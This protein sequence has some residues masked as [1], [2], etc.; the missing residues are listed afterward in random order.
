MKNI[1][2]GRK[3]IVMAVLIG[4]L[5]LIIMASLSF[6]YARI[7]LET[8]VDKQTTIFSNLAIQKLNDHFESIKANAELASTTENVRNMLVASE[9]PH[10]TEADLKSAQEAMTTFVES[11][12]DTLGYTEVFITDAKG[13]VVVANTMAESLMDA[14]LSSRDYLKS[15]LTGTPQWSELF[16]SD[17]VK[18]NVMLYSQPIYQLDTGGKI[19]GTIN[20]VFD[21][22]ALN[23]IV[24]YAVDEIGVTGNAYII[25]AEGML[26]T[27]MTIGEY[28][29]NAAMNATI[30][31][32]AVQLLKQEI[33][34]GNIAYRHSGHYNDIGE[35]QVLGTLSVVQFGRLHGGLIIE[36]N[37]DEVFAGT[38]RLMMTQG[39]LAVVAIIFALVISILISRS[40]T[41]PINELVIHADEIANYNIANDIPEAYTKRKDEIGD[42]ASALNQV[43][44]NLKTLLSE[45]LKTAEMVAA[46]SEQLTATSQQSSSAATEVAETIEEIARGASDQA[47]QTMQGTEQ[48]IVLGEHI[49]T[50][51]HETL[52][53]GDASG[54][55]QTLVKEGLALVDELI[56]TSESNSVATGIA[57]DAIIK[58]NESSTRISEA[59]QLIASIAD[60]TNLLALNAAIEAARAGEHGRGF[61]VVAD[62]IRKLAEQSGHSTQTIDQM[63][64]QLTV[65]AQTAVTK[66]TEI[67]DIVSAQ[68]D[69]VKA[70]ETKFNEIASAAET[71]TS[72]ALKLNSI[73]DEMAARKDV[74]AETL[75]T[76]SAVA[77]ENAASTEEASASMQEQTSSVEEIANSSE[78]LS[79]LAQDLQSL[80]QK[81][82]I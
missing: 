66:M 38:Q 41:K 33:L 47:A 53:L 32:E 56:E 15:S 61:A 42:I 30:D 28:Q 24:Q 78:D 70:S 68:V 16:Y 51:K 71:S 64:A 37:A 7:E 22:T 76:L 14:D 50:S 75:E 60:Q 35:N 55:T 9:N 39:T 29:S 58:T 26:L 43:I 18:E 44:K 79:R 74:V 57:Y 31:T 81:F 40:I 10:A 12:I 72:I 49:E 34:N 1:K 13:T 77:E 17:V 73:N 4:L 36:V 20:I 27:D 62:E 25:N 48:L 8:A 19:V 54:K 46:S 23:N 5:P 82:K 63:V 67:R 45:I 11:M 65:D 6:I 52:V 21:Q 2:M 69:S 3:L 80:I 59:S